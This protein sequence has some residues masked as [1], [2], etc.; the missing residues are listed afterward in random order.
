[1]RYSRCH[2]GRSR[3][4]AGV[5]LGTSVKAFEKAACAMDSIPDEIQQL[6]STAIKMTEGRADE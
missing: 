6:Y 4:A 2:S 1:V 3:S 5:C